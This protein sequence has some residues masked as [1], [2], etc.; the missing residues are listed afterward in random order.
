MAQRLGKAAV[1]EQADAAAR[2]LY[3]DM[4]MDYWLVEMG[5]PQPA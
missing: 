4:K 5:Q 2:R 3:T 1:A